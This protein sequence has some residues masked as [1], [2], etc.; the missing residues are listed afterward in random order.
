VIV[1]VRIFCDP[2]CTFISPGSQVQVLSLL[3]LSRTK[4]TA[5]QRYPQNANRGYRS[6]VIGHFVSSV[7][8]SFRRKSLPHR[9]F[10]TVVSPP[11]LPH[12]RFPTVASPPSLRRPVERVKSYP[13]LANDLLPVTSW[14]R[15]LPRDEMTVAVAMGKE[16][17]KRRQGL[18]APK[19]NRHRARLAIIP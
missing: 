7:V 8:S 4:P 11:S 16:D 15:L 2:P 13:Q 1:E 14:S 5:N 17:E 6:V 3:L 18:S 9:R 12:R 10:P 19:P